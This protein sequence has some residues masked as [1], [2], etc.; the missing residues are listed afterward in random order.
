MLS[1][2]LPEG[3]LS[4]AKGVLEIK[5]LQ[6]PTCPLTPSNICVVTQYIKCGLKVI[7]F[8]IGFVSSVNKTFETRTE[9]F[10]TGQNLGRLMQQCR[11]AVYCRR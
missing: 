9:P 2:F 5:I 6:G 11:N 7:M 3:K 1:W 8:E 4:V 10:E